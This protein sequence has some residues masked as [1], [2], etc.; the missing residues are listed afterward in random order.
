MSFNFDFTQAKLAKC[1]S[2][3]KN[4]AELFETFNTVLPKYNIT[5]VERVAAFLAQCG[6]ESAD[7]TVLKENL[8]YS[9]E[10]LSK[11]FP[12]RFPTVAAAQPYNRNPEKIAN[13][14]YADRMGNGPEASGEGF[15]FR[16]RGAIQLTGKEN[17]TKFAAR[18]GKT[19][20][21]AVAYTETLDGAIESACWFWT[22]NKLNDIADKNDI[23]TLT[24]RINGGT[25]G[26]EDRKHHFENNLITLS[27]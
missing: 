4:I 1:L 15:K 2:R 3:N 24:K 19:L 7:F 5:T 16:G 20:D 18:V 26:L 27:A 17:Y 22:T 23:V 6:H 11:V 25:I 9:A 12:K 8:N 21:E 10:G 14:I 13:K